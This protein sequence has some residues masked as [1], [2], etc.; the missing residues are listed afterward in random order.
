MTKDRALK[1]IISQQR[2]TIKALK[3]QGEKC[4]IYI[5]S[6]EA[7]IEAANKILD[8]FPAYVFADPVNGTVQKIPEIRDWLLELHNCLSSQGEMKK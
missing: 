3:E 6:L 4:N 8:S 2:E 5:E 1:Q 7:K